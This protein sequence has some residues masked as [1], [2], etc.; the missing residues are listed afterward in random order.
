M[1]LCGCTEGAVLPPLQHS[2]RGRGKAWGCPVSAADP[3]SVRGTAL[4]CGSARWPVFSSCCPLLFPSCICIHL[5]PLTLSSGAWDYC[6]SVGDEHMGSLLQA[7]GSPRY[8]KA[9]RGGTCLQHRPNSPRSAGAVEVLGVPKAREAGRLCS[10]WWTPNT[11]GPQG[12]W[13]IHP[14]HYQAGTLG[15]SPHSAGS[16][17][18]GQ[19]QANCF[20]M[21]PRHPQLAKSAILNWNYLQMHWISFS[22]VLVSSR[23]YGLDSKK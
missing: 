11:E 17:K 21:Q 9:N 3:R 13:A 16:D 12:D 23:S 6:G 15:T 14:P 8:H 5:Q 18:S 10:T 22:L 4:L 7:W 2:L 1:L 19:S 20:H